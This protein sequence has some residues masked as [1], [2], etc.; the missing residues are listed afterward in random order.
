MKTYVVEITQTLNGCIEMQ[1]KSESEAL[2]KARDM[3]E[4]D[5]KRLPDMDDCNGLDF[6][7]LLEK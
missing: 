3:Y 2:I 7:I 5:G 4:R 1:A 6:C